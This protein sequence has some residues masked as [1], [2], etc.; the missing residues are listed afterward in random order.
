MSVAMPNLPALQGLPGPAAE[1]LAGLVA[2]LEKWNARINLV[3][4]GTLA[5]VWRRHIADSAQLFAL[6]PDRL[7]TGPGLW[8]DLGSGGGFPGL[9][10]AALAV[11]LAPGLIVELVE[12]DARKCAFL[13]TAAQ[14]LALPARI[15]RSRI[16]DLAPRQA[17]VISARA[18]APLDRLLDMALP[19][20][21]P[22]GLCFFPKGASFPAEEVAARSRYRFDLDAVPSQTDASGVIARITALGLR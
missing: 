15:T 11:D 9:V 8:L 21:A 22:Q 3:A 1:R 6:M 16:E 7:R 20:L 4:P 10:I 19:H 5:D 14:T 13:Q 2:L 12:S 17:D 18:L